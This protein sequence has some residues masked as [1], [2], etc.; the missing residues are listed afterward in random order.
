MIQNKRE[1]LV[2]GGEV[3]Q[4]PEIIG[5]RVGLF[6][7]NR[8]RE[9]PMLFDSVVQVACSM[10]AETYQLGDTVMAVGCQ[11]IR[12]CPD[13]GMIESVDAEDVYLRDRKYTQQQ[14]NAI[15][16]GDFPLADEPPF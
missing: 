1:N 6:I 5:D 10:K 13:T 16:D 14:L 8:P 11:V 15:V 4:M 2:V 7:A 12:R 3:I 9:N